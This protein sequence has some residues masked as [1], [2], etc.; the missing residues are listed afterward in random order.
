[1]KKITVRNAERGNEE[2]TERLREKKERDR[3]GRENRRDNVAGGFARCRPWM[4]R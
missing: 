2:E 3:E 1:M 4:G